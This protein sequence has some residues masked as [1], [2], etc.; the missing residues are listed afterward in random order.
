MKTILLVAAIVLLILAVRDIL[1]RQ[2]KLLAFNL[3]WLAVVV[4]IPIVGPVLYF[5]LREGMDANR[6]RKFDP[7]FR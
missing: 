3:V 6:P 2:L 7:K 5:M 1:K 4:L